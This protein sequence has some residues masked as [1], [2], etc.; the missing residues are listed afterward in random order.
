MARTKGSTN[1]ATKTKRQIQDSIKNKPKRTRTVKPKAIVDINENYRILLDVN[2]YVLQRKLAVGEV[3]EKVLDE[4][5]DDEEVEVVEV[6]PDAERWTF[7]GY[8]STNSTGMAHLLDVCC[9]DLT[10]RQ[11]QDKR[12]KLPQ[13]MQEFR[14]NYGAIKGQLRSLMNP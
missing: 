4:L 1:V 3:A 13:Y 14:T 5:E 6:V 9:H 10:S 11:L 8:F 12:V 2:N 7:A